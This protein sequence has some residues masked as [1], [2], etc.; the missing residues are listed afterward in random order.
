[1]N[2]KWNEFG[3]T[4]I[5]NSNS[6]SIITNVIHNSNSVHNNFLYNN[7]RNNDNDKNTE[8]WEKNNNSTC[9]VSK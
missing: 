7:K 4:N 3:L 9:I 1:M 6:N 8:S 5:N 2:Y